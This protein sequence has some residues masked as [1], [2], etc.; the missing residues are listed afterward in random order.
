MLVN[1]EA[2]KI[3]IQW[4]IG[5]GTH[6]AA[7]GEPWY[8]GWREMQRGRVQQGGLTVAQLYDYHTKQ[9]RE[10]L[11]L[12]ILGL[13]A[14]QQIQ[15]VVRHPVQQPVLEDRIILLGTKK[16]KYT[17]KEGYEAISKANTVRPVNSNAQ[18]KAFKSI[19]K[20]KEIVPRVRLFLWRALQ[21]GLTTTHEMARRIRTIRPVCPHC[22]QEN[23]FTMH[24]LFFLPYL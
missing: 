21:N 23:E 1:K 4:Q 7:E 9:W 6:I 11:I 8:N 16:G 15:E 10:D 5:D 24:L 3:N 18:L 22:S 12:P 14:L 17:V 13:P 20:W 19:W 2:I